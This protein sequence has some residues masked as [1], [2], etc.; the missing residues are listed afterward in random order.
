MHVDGTQA[1]PTILAAKAAKKERDITHHT[2][3]NVYRCLRFLAASWKDPSPGGY[4]RP[5]T[6]DVATAWND[7]VMNQDPWSARQS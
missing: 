2:R 6:M 4:G 3:T 5:T 1:A 7:N